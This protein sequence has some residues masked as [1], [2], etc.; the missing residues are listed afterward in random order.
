MVL[1]CI[2]NSFAKVLNTII[3]KVIHL[4]FPCTNT[5]IYQLPSLSA[6]YRSLS[7]S[8]HKGCNQGMK[9]NKKNRV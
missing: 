7:T 4:P 1:K 8:L 6:L 3:N 2:R 5:Y 9:E